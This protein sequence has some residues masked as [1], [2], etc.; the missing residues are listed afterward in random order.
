MAETG[1]ITIDIGTADLGRIDLL[2]RKGFYSNRVDLVRTAVLNQLN[3][4]V[5]AA[6]Q[7]AVRKVSAVGMTI[8]SRAELEARWEAGEMIEIR[9]IGTLFIEN[10][11]PPELALATIR[12]VTVVRG[13]VFQAADAV[14]AA[15][16]EAGRILQPGHRH[17]RRVVSR[18][19]S[20]ASHRLA[21]ARRSD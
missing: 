16:D 7:T 18:A 3:R 19:Y 9:V 1:K 13:G 8:T 4:H 12:S 11:V 10:D 20:G 14:R 6:G 5:E 17:P 15:L 2:V 21:G